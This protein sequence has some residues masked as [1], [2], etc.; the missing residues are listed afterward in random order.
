MLLCL[1]GYEIL[2]NLYL[3]NKETSILRTGPMLIGR[4]HVFVASKIAPPNTIAPPKMYFLP[5]PI[6]RLLGSFIET[7]LL[8]GGGLLLRPCYY[9]GGVFS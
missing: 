7:R 6:L 4:L 8:F 1:L 3:Y 9:L 2:W 5:G